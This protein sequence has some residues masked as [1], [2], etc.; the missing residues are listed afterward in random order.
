[1][2]TLMSF[3]A[4]VTWNFC[5]ALFSLPFAS[6]QKVSEP[7]YPEL[8]KFAVQFNL[9]SA[10]LLFWQ[11]LY[12]FGHFQL[13]IYCLFLMIWALTSFMNYRNYP[14]VRRFTLHCSMILSFTSLRK[15]PICLDLWFPSRLTNAKAFCP[16]A[17]DHPLWCRGLVTQTRW[18]HRSWFSNSFEPVLISAT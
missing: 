13:I 7:S 10:S 9:Q 11:P 14:R 15:A 18:F 6:A 2:L 3:V 4:L 5:E 12:S 1:M 16:R 17:P 8:R